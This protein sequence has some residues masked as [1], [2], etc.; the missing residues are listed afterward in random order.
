MF[1]KDSTSSLLLLLM[2]FVNLFRNERLVQQLVCVSSFGSQNNS[3]VGQNAET[4]AGM[5]DR[6]HRIFDLIEATFGREDGRTSVITSGLCAIRRKKSEPGASVDCLGSY[7]DE[8]MGG[9]K[10]RARDLKR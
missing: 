2:K 10:S 7:H 3:V 4:R 6:L 5:A 8:A 1:K 9:G